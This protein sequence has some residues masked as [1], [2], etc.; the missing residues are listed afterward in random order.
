M[1]GQN[2]AAAAA[3]PYPQ[4]RGGRLGFIFIGW[5]TLLAPAALLAPAGLLAPEFLELRGDGA[6]RR[7]PFD[8]AVRHPN[9]HL[10]L[11]AVGE[12]SPVHFFGSAGARRGQAIDRSGYGTVD[13]K[14]AT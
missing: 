6:I 4:R 5:G 14:V 11:A 3:F 7:A 13:V 8:A 2:S 12:L 9:A 1:P 10:L